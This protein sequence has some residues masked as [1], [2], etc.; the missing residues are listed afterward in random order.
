MELKIP[1]LK[2]LPGS[3]T[4]AWP[5]HAISQA[6]RTGSPR[7]GAMRLGMC[8]ASGQ[9]VRIASSTDARAAR[10][11]SARV[12]VGEGAHRTLPRAGWRAARVRSRSRARSAARVA[13]G[14]AKG[15]R[16][17]LGRPVLIR[18]AW[19]WCRGP[20]GCE[21]HRAGGSCIAAHGRQRLVNSSHG[22]AALVSPG[23]LSRSLEL[24]SASR[25]STRRAWRKSRGQS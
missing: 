23:C 11:S 1:Q 25:A 17:G 3:W 8:S 18:G 9:L 12:R 4:I 14:E 5:T 21:Q 16:G 13:A 10:A 19:G 7:S 15:V 24:R 20:R 2:M 6:V 22:D